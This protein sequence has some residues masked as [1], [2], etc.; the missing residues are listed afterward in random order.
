MDLTALIEAL[1]QPGAYPYPVQQIEVRQTHISAVFLAGDYV[2]KVK[3]PVN[4][5]FLDFSTPEKRLHFCHEEVR[6][7]RRLAP[8]VYHG[9][10]PIARSATGLLQ[11]EA[12]GPPIEWAVK[13]QRLPDHA[14]L[15]AYLERDAITPELV[16]KVAERM[17]SFH[18]HAQRGP[19]I[20]AAGRFEVVAAN[21]RE[22]FA[23]TQNH[24]GVTVTREVFQ[25]VQALT[26]TALSQLQ[27]LIDA[28]ASRGMP[29]DTHGDLHLDHIYYFP[30]QPPP[31]D[32]L[33]ID[34][35]EFA[36]RF[37]HADPLADIAFLAMDLA[38][39]HRR[40]LAK[41]LLDNYFRAANDPDGAALAPFYTAYRAV[42]RAKVEGLAHT[43]TEIPPA[44][45][46]FARRQAQAY[47]L[48]AL[49]ELETPSRRP[50]LV[51][52]A[53]LP[54]SGKSTLARRL[55]QAV[56]FDVLR[57]DV[58]RKQLAGLPPEATT[59]DAQDSGIYTPE[60]TERTYNECRQR[61]EAILQRGGRVIVDANFPDEN[62]R[63][64]FVELAHQLAIPVLILWCQASRDVAKQRILQRRHDASDANTRTYDALEARWQPFG[65]ATQRS[66]QVVRADGPPDELLHQ[67]LQILKENGLAE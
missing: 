60:W 49:A 10:V 22:N 47:W 17:A 57:T 34:C 52:M 14:T 63:R 42:V 59:R 39:H 27:P 55:A 62:R 19:H 53:G 6:L 8:T 12:D 38:F 50:A 67:A 20:A 3:K 11:F 2:Y 46:E 13:M 1:S 51:L 36:D 40:D 25:R 16:G 7:N 44:K 15:W 45:R 48:L 33:A 26:E 35:I 61:A 21:A 24:V 23:Q 28:R 5:G 56:P 41:L 4:F 9:V 58:V 30:D 32:L 31:H 43:E 54:G 64:T 37:R 66:V 18:A 29:C 65:P